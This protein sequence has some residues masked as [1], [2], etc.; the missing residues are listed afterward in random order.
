[1]QDSLRLLYVS[2]S[3]GERAI[4]TAL[5]E[6]A[7]YRLEVRSVADAADLR[8][9]LAGADFDLVI[10]STRL[11]GW[12]A[13]SVIELL[14]EA[15]P[16]LPVIALGFGVDEDAL[17]TL[18]RVGAFTVVRHSEELVSAVQRGLERAENLRSRWLD[19]LSEGGVRIL[20]VDDEDAVL[21]VARRLLQRLG[22]MVAAFHGP[23]RALAYFREHSHSFDLAITDCSLESRSGL[24]LASELREVRPALP[25]LLMTGYSEY[26]G[27]ERVRGS[28]VCA[29]IQKPFRGREL[30]HAVELAIEGASEGQARAAA[31]G[32]L[33]G[34]MPQR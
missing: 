13:R 25:V 1:M 7:G 31:H 17:L 15:V 2:S 30:A 12:D 5:L 22:H 18:M 20:L 26:L 19:C 8:G 34:S 16:A 29:V 4:S 11:A 21:R 24:V 9:A 32:K 3:A 27:P 6:S 14:R 10:C 33:A 28:G 23:D